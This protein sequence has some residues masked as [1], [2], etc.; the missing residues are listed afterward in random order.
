MQEKKELGDNGMDF[1]ESIEQENYMIYSTYLSLV[2]EGGCSKE[3]ALELLSLNEEQINVY[4]KLFDPNEDDYKN[5]KIDEII[6]W[7]DNV[8]PKD[9]IDNINYESV[10]VYVFLRDEFHSSDITKNYLFQFVYRSFYRL[11]NA[12]LTDEFKSRY[13]EL[14]EE[15]KYNKDLNL[16]NILHELFQYPNLK[17]EKT[18]LTKNQNTF[19]FSFA[20]K[21]LNTID[22]NYAIYDSKVECIFGFKKI[23][24]GNFDKKFE[25]YSKYLKEI[26]ES[27]NTIISNEYLSNYIKHFDE[28]FGDKKLSK[29]KKLDFIFWSAGK[30]KQINNIKTP[31]TFPL[32]VRGQIN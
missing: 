10:D 17:G 32:G 11:D 18:K 25:T 5:A 27:Y 6:N 31:L 15:N 3:K 20:T 19:Q 21:M 1:D 14:L 30:I 26:Q 28:R 12:G 24:S 29:I 7:F 8:N 4:R 9:V 2:E 22:D 13:F 23:Y 16:K